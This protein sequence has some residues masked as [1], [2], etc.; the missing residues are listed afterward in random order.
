MVLNFKQSFLQALREID[1]IGKH[2]EFL[3]HESEEEVQVHLSKELLKRYGDMK[4]K[5]VDTLN[6]HY[7]TVLK[8]QFDL[9]NWLNHNEEDEVAYFLNEVGSN[10]LNH[11][12]YKAPFKFHLWMG[13]KGFMLGVEQKGKGFPAKLIHDKKLRQNEGAAF[14]FFRN[15]QSKIFF[16]DPHDAKMVFMSYKL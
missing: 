8:N 12:Q 11:S 2:H 10:C 15:C 14:D 9:Y 16:D 6:Q 5:V 13:K 3:I 1:F 7:T 4:W